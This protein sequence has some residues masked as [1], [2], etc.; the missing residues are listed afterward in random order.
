MLFYLFTFLPFYR[1]YM[2]FTL[3]LFYHFTF[4]L[5]TFLSLLYTKYTAG[6]RNK[7]AATQAVGSP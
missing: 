7:S 2:P 3:L 6:A 4:Y 1:S 5:L